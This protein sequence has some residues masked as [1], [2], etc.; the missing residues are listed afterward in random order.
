MLISALLFTSLLAIEEQPQHVSALPPAAPKGVQR[1][2]SA[3]VGLGGGWLA[4]SDNIGR[5]GQGAWTLRGRIAAG[6]AVDWMLFLAAEASGTKRADM[7]FVQTTLLAG[8]QRFLA[9]RFYVYSGV[10]PSW[11]TQNGPTED[12][13]SY[14]DSVGPGL[15]VTIGLGLEALRLA[16]SAIGIELA[17]TM[18]VF[19]RERWDSGGLNLTFVWY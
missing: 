4:L 17:G 9:G 18:G 7:T 13:S 16:H 12:G 2:V 3:T 15:G 14:S 11:V 6:F 8:V 19:A 1:A 5:D 10:G